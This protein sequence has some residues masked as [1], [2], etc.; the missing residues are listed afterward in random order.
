M[1]TR[2]IPRAAVNSSLRVAR[3][4][5]DAA[6]NLLPGDGTGIKPAAAAAVD[7]V[8][9]GTRSLLGLVLNDTELREDARQRREALA[10]RQRAGNLREE[11]ERKSAQADEQL[12]RRQEKAA[13]TRRRA[14]QRANSRREAARHDEEEKRRR[15][16]EAEKERLEA[17]QRTTE[18]VEEVL[19]Q[20]EP[21][22]RLDALTAQDEAQREKEKELA[23]RDE[24]RRLEHAAEQA[25]ADRKTD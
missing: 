19:D 12:E 7:R 21:R 14:S 2:A 13:Q 16:A 17:N 6:I 23:A 8:D 1:N 15:A 18:R 10:G 3:L 24:A 5:F 11:A 9:A 22:E 20:R 25:K 4:P